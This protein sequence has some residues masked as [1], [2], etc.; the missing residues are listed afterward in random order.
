MVKVKYPSVLSYERSIQPSLGLFY[1]LGP[2]GSKTPINVSRTK[3]KGTIAHHQSEKD[4]EKAIGRPN[5]QEIESAY[6]PISADTLSVEYSIVFLN[7][8]LE[9][10][11][12]NENDYNS[13]LKE[14]ALEYK[15]AEGYRILAELYFK[16]IKDGRWLWRNK[17]MGAPEVKF[18]E[19]LTDEQII[20][21]IMEA[22]S[23]CSGKPFILNVEGKIKLAPNQEVFPSQEFEEKDKA[24]SKDY[25]VSR[26]L[27][28]LESG[29]AYFHSQKIG[30]AIRTIDT[31]YN[32]N[33]G[34]RAIAIEPYGVD[35]GLQKAFRK[36]KND[37]YTYLKDI[38]QLIAL[39]K[40][41]DLSAEKSR[42]HFVMACLI[43]GGVYGF[44]ISSKE[45]QSE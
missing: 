29:Q 45:G 14:L 37:L 3:I 28:K 19:H 31:W 13:K 38:D 5:L 16:N 6:L 15:K 22:L 10:I 24:K 23:D 4:V 43:R 39:C 27:A 33:G 30:N 36:E 8:S 21:S 18:R 26:V 12:C 41:G 17:H 44:G 32:E 25:E 7:S 42:V 1:G 2:S 20:S 11:M 40:N 9:P 35:Q 34:T